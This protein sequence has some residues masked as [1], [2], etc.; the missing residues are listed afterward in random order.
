MKLHFQHKLLMCVHV[1]VCVK[2]EALFPKRGKGIQGLVYTSQCTCQSYLKQQHHCWLLHKVTNHASNY[3][4]MDGL[5]TT[6]KL[7]LPE[8]PNSNSHHSKGYF[9]ISIISEGDAAMFTAQIH[10]C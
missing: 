5:P 8:A 1:C 7:S 4:D 6:I 2:N 3:D 9:P 10:F